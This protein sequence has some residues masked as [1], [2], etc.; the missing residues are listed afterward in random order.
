VLQNSTSSNLLI[1]LAALFTCVGT[2]ASAENFE[3]P[4]VSWSD[5]RV[6]VEAKTDLSDGSSAMI[7]I[8]GR[9]DGDKG[10]RGEFSARVTG[11][12]LIGSG[13]VHFVEDTIEDHINAQPGHYLVVI[14]TDKGGLYTFEFAGQLEKLDRGSHV[15]EER[16]HNATPREPE[17]SSFATDLLGNNVDTSISEDEILHEA[18]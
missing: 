1:I 6:R 2:H 16:K 14:S 4:K 11:G 8:T 10:I 18:F 17:S 13:S 15:D 7:A 9:T 3:T 5:T 12:Y